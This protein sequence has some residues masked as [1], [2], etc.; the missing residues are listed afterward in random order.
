MIR[1]INEGSGTFDRVL[2]GATS[3]LKRAENKFGNKAFKDAINQANRQ[4]DLNRQSKELKDGLRAAGV[5][6]L[7]ANRIIVMTKNDDSGKLY[8]EI[9]NR[10]YDITPEAA[11]AL[12][13]SFD[14]KNKEA[15]DVQDLISDTQV[16]SGRLELIQKL[17]DKGW[18]SK[19][20][21]VKSAFSD[22]ST[23]QEQLDCLIYAMEYD[24]P[25]EEF[26]DG[27]R[28]KK[29]NT[30]ILQ[31]NNH[32][33]EILKTKQEKAK[34]KEEIAAKHGLTLNQFNWLNK[35]FN[36]K[37]YNSKDAKKVYDLAASRLLLGE[38]PED[39]ENYLKGAKGA[40]DNQTV[41]VTAMGLSDSQ[42]AFL[43]SLR[44]RSS[45]NMGLAIDNKTYYEAANMLKNGSTSQDVLKFV[46]QRVL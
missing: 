36:I 40:K 35:K 11:G 43:D 37:N 14:I 34:A 18:G 22:P 13:K 39:V 27:D 4:R 16:S 28:P 1:E 29:Y 46:L 15:D 7:D 5:S 12:L 24:L 2:G 38:K 42:I 41:N 30:M 25:L 17:V 3:K 20:G 8:Q 19:V 21:Q 44:K 45:N 9:V 6:E 33:E 32:K 26:M 10:K 31:L 23:T